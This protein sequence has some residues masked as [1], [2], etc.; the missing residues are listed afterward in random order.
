MYDR[1]QM[2][3]VVWTK[4]INC[5]WMALSRIPQKVEEL[6]LGRQKAWSNSEQGVTYDIKPF[7][8]SSS[9]LD[10][11]DV[12]QGLPVASTES[13]LYLLAMA[14][15]GPAEQPERVSITPLLKRLAY[16]TANADVRPE[17]IASAFSLIFENCLSVTQLSAFL[18]LLHSTGKDKHPEVIARCASGMREAASQVDKS[19]L[20]TAVRRKGLKRGSYRGGLVR[21]RSTQGASSGINSIASV[22]LLAL[23]EIL[24]QHSTSLPHLR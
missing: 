1:D 3:R 2:E 19:T 13:T 20:R 6:A 24:T 18:T 22:I 17:E 9:K 14:S 7:Q 5:Q 21:D 16:P 10:K 23:A 8:G 11:L 4:G 15:E 12:D